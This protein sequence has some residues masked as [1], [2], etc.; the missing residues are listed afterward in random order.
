MNRILFNSLATA[1]F[2]SSL[3]AIAW[4]AGAYTNG[5]PVVQAPTASPAAGQYYQ[6]LTG[7]E[8]IPMDTGLA[9]GAAPQT[10][11]V[12][13]AQLKAYSR[14]QVALTAGSTV[15]TNAANALLFTLAPVQSFTLS[16][17]TNLVSGQSIQWQITQDGTGSRVATYGNAFTFSG[18][19]T[20][21]T[22]AGYV[23]IVSCIYDGTAAKLRCVVSLHYT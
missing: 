5:F 7:S 1:G 3:A 16:N 13:P 8:L 6:P 15:A 10:V 14:P 4:G 2:L 17:P 12:T 18:S 22:S 9:G 19:S 20:L 23:D 11:A 21:S